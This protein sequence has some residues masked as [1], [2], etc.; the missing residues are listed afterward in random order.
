MQ[1]GRIRF[2]DRRADRDVGREAGMAP[3]V[4]VTSPDGHPGDAVHQSHARRETTTANATGP[5]SPSARGSRP[6]TTPAHPGQGAD[7]LRHL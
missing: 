6:R 5:L 7:A 1:P 2:V 4:V 3:P